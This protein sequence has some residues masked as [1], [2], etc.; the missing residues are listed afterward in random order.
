M[1]GRVARSIARLRLVRLS[2]LVPHVEAMAPRWLA[3]SR[4]AGLRHPIRHDV[5]ACDV[6]THRPH[7][8]HVPDAR[9]EHIPF[10]VT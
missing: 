5:G 2:E 7:T 6:W 10:L 3:S 9:M 8:A 1:Q 4:R